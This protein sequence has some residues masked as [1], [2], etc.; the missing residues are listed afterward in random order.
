MTAGGPNISI[1]VHHDPG[2]VSRP[3]PR[4]W[5]HKPTSRVSVQNIKLNIHVSAQINHYVSTNTGR[6]CSADY[7]I[8]SA[9]ILGFVP[10]PTLIL[11]YILVFSMHLPNPASRYLMWKKLLTISPH[12]D[13]GP[14]MMWCE[15]LDN[16]QFNKFLRNE[17]SLIVWC[18]AERGAEHVMSSWT[19][20]T[21]VIISCHYPPARPHII[22]HLVFPW[23]SVLG[24]RSPL[25][26]SAPG[27][28]GQMLARVKLH[29]HYYITFA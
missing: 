9:Y 16:L 12:W 22:R 13:C 15:I 3:P 7:I 6:V 8:L 5:E 24:P 20:W 2:R 1:M 17:W 23:E 11:R 19:Q 29:L 28:Q 14:V 26:P 18:E 4:S 10:L 21:I 27:G 25:G